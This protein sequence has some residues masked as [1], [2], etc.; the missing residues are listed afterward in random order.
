M[1]NI[2][3]KK[4]GGGGG[5]EQITHVHLAS[6]C[7]YFTFS[8]KTSSLKITIML[9]LG[10]LRFINKFG[11]RPEVCESVLLISL[12]IPPEKKTGVGVQADTKAFSFI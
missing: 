10:H 2:Y 8:A 6:S 7:A 1:Q 4:G 11:Q 3:F 12:F 9:E 5:W